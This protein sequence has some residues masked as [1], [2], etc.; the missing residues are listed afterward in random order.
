MPREESTYA[1]DWLRVANRD[2][3]RAIRLLEDEDAEGAA[4]HLQQAA[5][6]FLKAYLLSTGWQLE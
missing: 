1:A 4:M 3:D 2:L 6:K 5:E